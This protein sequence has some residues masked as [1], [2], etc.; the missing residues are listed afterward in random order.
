MS[1]CWTLKEIVT[2]ERSNLAQQLGLYLS[3]VMHTASPDDIDISAIW[4]SYRASLP[5]LL[6][7]SLAAAVIAFLALSTVHSRY[8]S[9][10]QIQVVLP[11]RDSGSG[12]SSAQEVTARLDK[13]AIN[14]HV[15]AIMSPDLARVIIKEEGLEKLPEFNPAM[16]HA[17]FL[18]GIKNDVMGLLLGSPSKES[19]QDRVLDAY[20]D[21]LDVYSPRESRFIGIRFT[22]EDPKLAANVANAIADSYRTAVATRTV[23]GTDEVQK[24]LQPRIDSLQK[25]VAEA[26]EAVERFR[27]KANIF[28]GGSNDT[29]LNQQQL[30]EVTAE[31]SRAQAARN[32]AESRALSVRQMVAAG[33]TE[34]LPDVQKSPLI[35]NLVQQRVRLQR[36]LSELSATLLPAHPRM[37][38][39]RAD[40]DGLERQIKSEV[41]KVVDGVDKNAKVA[42]LRVEAVQKSLDDMKK[43]VVDKGD[44]QVKLRQLEA[45]AKSKRAELDRLQARYEAN[46]ARAESRAIPIE[47][48]IIT[49]ARP[50]SVPSFPKRLPYAAIVAAAIFLFG[51]AIVITRALFR[52]ARPPSAAQKVAWTKAAVA[53]KQPRTAPASAAHI[54][55][56]KVETIDSVAALAE[57]LLVRPPDVGGFRT[58]I[59]G[60]TDTIDASEEALA[61]AKALTEAGSDVMLI[62]WAPDGQGSA[63]AMGVHASVGMGD[64]LEGK[65]KFEDVVQRVPGSNAHIIPAGNAMTTDM[66]DADQLNLV[67]DALDTAYDHIVVAGRQ[68]AARALFEAIQGRFDAGVIVAEGKRRSAKMSE[69]P[70]TFLGFEVTDIELFRLERGTSGKVAKERLS[71]ASKGGRSEVRPA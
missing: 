10:A 46:R 17:S 2:G 32:E 26:D 55:D 57:Q 56:G 51:T 4:R 13:E 49:T 42:A 65:A 14:T 66:A 71:R 39:I 18:T 52:A 24:A 36:Q 19:E 11:E 27:G 20:Y 23:A 58:L 8:T 25:E 40:L 5:K 22:S 21:R 38:Q 62:D 68:P 3:V 37:R 48:Q 47:A 63:D 59:T 61:L 7:A 64:L 50:S 1:F 35:Q 60:D 9:E 41:A 6:L 30:A 31:L 15:R 33:N 70:G 16:G 67:L 53:A 12:D 43:N 45:I 44:D 29:G 69:A 34:T 54:P 28:K